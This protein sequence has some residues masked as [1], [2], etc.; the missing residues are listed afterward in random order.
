MVEMNMLYVG[1]FQNSTHN[2]LDQEWLSQAPNH[3]TE[4]LPEESSWS[5]VVRVIEAPPD[6]KLILWADHLEQ[7]ALLYLD[8]A[9]PH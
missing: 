5:E 9:K 6:R 7:Q 4:L 2:L 3:L 1:F 8:R